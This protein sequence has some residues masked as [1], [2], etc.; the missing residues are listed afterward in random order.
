MRFLCPVLPLLDPM[1]SE[2]RGALSGELIRALVGYGSSEAL[3]D[4]SDNMS[5]S[6]SRLR[7][8]SSS[9]LGSI[10]SRVSFTRLCFVLNWAKARRFC[11]LLAICRRSGYVRPFSPVKGG[12]EHTY[13]ADF[14]PLQHPVRHNLG[15]LF[16][17]R[18]HHVAGITICIHVS[19][20]IRF[21]GYVR[22][23]RC[24]PESRLSGP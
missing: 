12:T 21:G 11:N 18:R 14:C 5:P 7:R 15:L 24:G 17:R 10:M 23:E 3:E 8:I 22:K 1:A 9:N 6:C 20:Q 13:F 2:N 4:E 19:C 16:Q